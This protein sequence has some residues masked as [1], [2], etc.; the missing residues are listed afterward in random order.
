VLLEPGEEPVQRV[1]A[2]QLDS[3]TDLPV[4]VLT[5]RLG[6]LSDAAMRQLCVALE[7]AAGCSS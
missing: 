3:L 7:V 4:D 2:A 5:R 6:R 1:C